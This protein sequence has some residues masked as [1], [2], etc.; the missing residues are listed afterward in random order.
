M[1]QIKPFAALRFASSLP[2][3]QLTCQ[4]YDVISEQQQ[5]QYYQQH[6]NNMI[7]LEWGKKYPNDTETDNVYSRA[8]ATFA[9]WQQTGVLVQEEQPAFYVYIQ[10][11][12][13]NGRQIRRT[14][15]LTRLK[16]CGYESGEV[17]PHEETLPGHKQDRLL[18]MQATYANFSPI[19]GL[20]AEPQRKIDQILAQAAHIP[21]RSA[22]IDF[23]DAQQ[24]RHLVYKVD[25]PPVLDQVVKLMAG[26]KIY[27]ADGHHRYE[28]ASRFAAEIAPDQEEASYIMINL[29]N[30]F[31]PGLIVLPTHRIVRNVVDF[32]PEQFF[33]RL[34]EN[35]I[36]ITAIQ[37]NGT[38]ENRDFLLNAMAKED[39]NTAA[40]GLYL[41]GNY[42]LLQLAKNEPLL[43]KLLAEHSQSYRELDVSIAHTMILE[44]CCNI[45][46]QEAASG[47]YISYT[48]SSQEAIDQVDEGNYQFA[49]LLNN[50]KVDELLAV[51]DAGEKMPQK[52]TFFYPKI[53]AGLTIN[54]LK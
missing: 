47:H 54:K 46:M 28:T 36:R 31:D 18:L 38:Q 53:I 13:I 26:L 11:F 25:E 7:R 41:C 43:T 20:Y 12:T 23:I 37:Q 39:H 17:A 49:L 15:F 30:L 33:R 27:I 51:A 50:T 45:G 29:V 34:R 35:H 21:H 8:A 40:I 14:G 16:A 32:S 10:E 3:D 24:I 44:S 5:E 2:I 52:S 22:D 9:K 6:Q 1:A 4:P 48:R 19:F 42:Y